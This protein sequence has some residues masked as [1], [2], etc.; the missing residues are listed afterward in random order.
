MLEISPQIVLEQ[1]KKQ[2]SN[3]IQA[4]LEAIYLICE[5]QQQ[6]GLNEFSYATIARLG[7]G[8]GVPA[9][10][11]IRN[12]T[13]EPYRS[14][15]ASFANLTPKSNKPV[16]KTN[17]GQSYAWIDELKDP[18]VRLQANILYSQKLTAERLVNEIV[19]INQVIEVFDGAA[20]AS[21]QAKLTDLEREAFEYL[22]ST[23][24]MRRQQLEFGPNGSILSFNSKDS[25]FPV[26]TIDAIKKALQYL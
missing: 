15:I 24:F 11:S 20:T 18:I 1:L 26:A 12:K 4:S 6:R 21:V 25:V 10:Q 2:V 3:K 5:E 16:A 8:R 13:G 17:K 22:I 14:L 23:E 19:P 7:K 9:A